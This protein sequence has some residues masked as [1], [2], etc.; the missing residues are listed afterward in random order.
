MVKLH[1]GKKGFKLF[2]PLGYAVLCFPHRSPSHFP[3]SPSTA[4]A[5]TQPYHAAPWPQ[6]HRCSQPLTRA[7]RAQL[8]AQGT[9]HS[10]LFFTVLFLSNPFPIHLPFLPHLLPI[11][12]L[13]LS[14]SLPFTCPFLFPSFPTPFPFSSFTL[15]ILFPLPF[16]STSCSFHLPIPLPFPLPLPFHPYSILLSPQ[17]QPTHPQPPKHPQPQRQAHTPA[18]LLA[19]EVQVRVAKPHKQ[20]LQCGA[21]A[22]DGVSPWYLGTGAA[23]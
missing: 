2:Q 13:S 20:R 14:Y 4:D 22:E 17:A 5:G 11:P 8:P 18:L 1:A 19:T 7:W 16:C 3:P 21:G 6:Q 10:W 15:C 23:A 12:L 9:L